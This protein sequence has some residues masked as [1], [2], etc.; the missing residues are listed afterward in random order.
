M[1]REMEEEEE[2]EEEEGVLPE[3]EKTSYNCMKSIIVNI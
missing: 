1:D 2:E 3:R